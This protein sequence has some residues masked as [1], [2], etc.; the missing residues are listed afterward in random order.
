MKKAMMNIG[1]VT[2][3]VVTF[4]IMAYGIAFGLNYAYLNTDMSYEVYNYLTYINVMVS[5]FVAM[6]TYHI[7]NKKCAAK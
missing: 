6:E 4:A 5:T 1:I 3:T 2:A 7:I